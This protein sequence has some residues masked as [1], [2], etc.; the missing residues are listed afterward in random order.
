MSDFNAPSE[1][2]SGDPEK[3]LKVLKLDDIPEDIQRQ[4]RDKNLDVNDP[5]L[6]VF[7]I[8]PGGDI[9]DYEEEIKALIRKEL[10]AAGEKP[11]EIKLSRTLR[12]SLPQVSLDH[13]KDKLPKEAQLAIEVVKTLKPD[14]L[15]FCEEEI[16]AS[17]KAN[18]VVL[19][20]GKSTDHMKELIRVSSVVS[21]ASFFNVVQRIIPDPEVLAS[22]GEDN[23]CSPILLMGSISYLI[24][25]E[26]RM[27]VAEK[28]ISAMENMML[29]KL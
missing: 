6:R 5:N 26:I 9:E 24:Q 14:L 13:I 27:C 28:L 25:E 20:S 4:L 29:H 8:P 18:E 19:S 1:E 10:E 21:M 17:A 16:L 15:K 23:D 2:S 12:E 11:D 3:H 22:L 7:S